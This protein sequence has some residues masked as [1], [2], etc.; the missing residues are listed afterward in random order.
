MESHE[1]LEPSDHE[2]IIG[3]KVSLGPQCKTISKKLLVQDR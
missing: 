1:A 2:P 3:K